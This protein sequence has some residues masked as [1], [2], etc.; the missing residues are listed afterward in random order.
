M[1]VVIS[2]LLITVMRFLHQQTFSPV[3]FRQNTVFSHI[4]GHNGASCIFYS[5]V[6]CDPTAAVAHIGNGTL[7][8]CF[9]VL[10]LV[11]HTIAYYWP[12]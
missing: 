4:P 2:V 5:T 1:R 9:C 7:V 3:R 10:I 8:V 6:S 11:R 12:L